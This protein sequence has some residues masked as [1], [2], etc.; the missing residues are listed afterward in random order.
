ME[1]YKFKIGDKIIIMDGKRI[2]QYFGG[3]YK[4]MKHLIGKTYKIED[5]SSVACFYHYKITDEIGN[6]WWIDE[7]GAIKAQADQV[8]EHPIVITDEITKSGRHKVVA[9]QGEFKGIAICHPEDEFDYDFGVTL[10][11]GRLLQAKK[12][13]KKK[14]AATSAKYITTAYICW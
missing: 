2:H 11:L 6:T 12:E 4:E 5:R 8:Y 9:S 14:K 7:R 3:W 1:N 10:A 13:A